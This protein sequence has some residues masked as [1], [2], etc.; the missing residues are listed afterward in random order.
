MNCRI[1]SAFFP[2]AVFS[3]GFLCILFVFFQKY[4]TYEL[5]GWVPFNLERFGRRLKQ[6]QN[7]Q[8]LKH[9]LEMLCDLYMTLCTAVKVSVIALSIQ[10]SLLLTLSP[11]LSHTF[12]VLALSVTVSLF[13]FGCRVYFAPFECGSRLH[14]S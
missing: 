5:S 9:I 1:W 13:S 8:Q 3:N 6:K 4:R 11:Y 2:L 14:D 12:S 7:Q 10:F